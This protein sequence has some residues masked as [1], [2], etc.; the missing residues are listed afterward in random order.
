MSTAPSP[1][2]PTDGI[3]V[4]DISPLRDGSDAIGVGKALHQA[5]RNVA[6]P[7]TKSPTLPP[8]DADEIVA[9]PENDMGP[10]ID[11][12]PET[13]AVRIVELI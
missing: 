10:L 9:L 13:P 3:P 11:R 6:E 12:A 5:S 2:S 4:I 1:T 7:R 8:S